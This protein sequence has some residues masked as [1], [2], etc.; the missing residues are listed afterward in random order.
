MSG[1]PLG[2]PDVGLVLR[3]TK[4]ISIL[5]MISVIVSFSRLNPTMSRGYMPNHELFVLIVMKCHEYSR[6][7]PLVSN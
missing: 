1:L 3:M 7:S 4:E 5:F 2:P 6:F